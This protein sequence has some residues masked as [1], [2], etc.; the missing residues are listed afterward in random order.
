M[1]F[2]KVCVHV[3]PYDVHTQVY[4]SIA[5]ECSSDLEAP[6]TSLYPTERERERE[7]WR[8]MKTNEGVRNRKRERGRRKAT[9]K[10]K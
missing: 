3:Q 2:V 9:T 1:K 4:N 10:A 5:T 7:A 8:Q 6:E